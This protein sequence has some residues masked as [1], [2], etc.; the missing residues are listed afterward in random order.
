M[1][2]RASPKRPLGISS[3]S[4]I[5]KRD[6][7]T[8]IRTFHRGLSL[9]DPAEWERSSVHKVRW[10]S[11]AA[12]KGVHAGPL[13]TTVGGLYAAVVIRHARALASNGRAEDAV[14]H[15]TTL[16]RDSSS[17]DVEPWQVVPTLEKASGCNVVIVTDQFF[18]SA[19]IRVLCCSA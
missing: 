17:P 7:E 1:V 3:S 9:E 4:P 11:G 19:L 16:L 10:P 12:L 5:T 13:S 15:L 6:L 18:A 8:C 2:A 14:R